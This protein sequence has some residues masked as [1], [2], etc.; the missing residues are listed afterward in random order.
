MKSF[1]K[2]GFRQFSDGIFR[3][4][5]PKSLE[6]RF[7][8]DETFFFLLIR[9][10]PSNSGSITKRYTLQE[11]AKCAT[12]IADEAAYTPCLQFY[13][14][15]YE[16]AAAGYSC[17]AIVKEL[18]SSRNTVTKISSRR[19]WGPVPLK[20]S[21]YI[22]KELS[23]GVHDYILSS[24]SVFLL[25]IFAAFWY[26]DLNFSLNSAGNKISASLPNLKK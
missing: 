19:L 17:R 1:W 22:I 16:Y 3:C 6:K 24:P 9:R 2:F 4:P 11:A 15:I 14:A 26:I 18:H 10:K 5:W 12:I 8:A 25:Y 7:L 20:L 23:A 21:H 13:Y